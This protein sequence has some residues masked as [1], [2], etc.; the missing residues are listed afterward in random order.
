MKKEELMDLLR[1]PAKY[2]QKKQ[3][4]QNPQG[5]TQAQSAATTEKRT[6]DT[7]L[8]GVGIGVVALVL[9]T[10]VIILSAQKEPIT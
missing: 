6:Q 10:I 2:H 9:I 7:L 1:N 4:A 3:A 8:L 5:A